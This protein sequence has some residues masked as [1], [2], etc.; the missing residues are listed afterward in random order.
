MRTRRPEP[1][2][3]VGAYALDA[4]P[5]AD[6][7]RF[8]RHLARCEQCDQEVS[9]LREV[10]ARLAAAA[11][12]QPSP[13]LTERAL[14]AAARTRQLPPIT[15]GTPWSWPARHAAAASRAAGHGVRLRRPWVF[16]ARRLTLA[17][18]GAMVILAGVFGL[19]AR[20]ALHQV[21][22]DQAR[23]HQIAA[24]LTARDATM[25]TARVT[26]GGTAAVV[27][28][29]RERAL[30]FVA[31]GLRPLPPSRCYELWLM[32]PGDDRPAAMLPGTG[33]GMNGPV[34]AS[35]LRPGDHLGLSIEPAGGSP[36]PTSPVI[37]QVAL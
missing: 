1:H 29:G 16:R 17:L 33:Q 15:R 25:I 30:V 37:L 14:A 35:G 19:A 10:A 26:T 4:L 23:G 21:Q 12:A 34:L 7:T 9:G 36:H 24:V 18:T 13:G 8:E 6:R 31:A 27:M 3:L 22:Q 2:T 5:P 32:A 20:S 11:A 28:S